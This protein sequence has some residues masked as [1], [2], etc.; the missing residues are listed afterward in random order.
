[1]NGTELSAEEQQELKAMQIVFISIAAMAFLF[2]LGAIVLSQL[3]GPLTPGLKEYHKW[4][5]GGAAIFSLA[6]SLWG[7]QQFARA[8]ETAKTSLNPLSGKLTMYRTSLIIYLA[9]TELPIIFC[10]ILSVLTG[11]FVFQVYAAVLL[12]FM[13]PA[14]PRKEKVLGQLQ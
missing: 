1:M 9:I 8:V 2:L 12:G 7:K 3:R 13:L 14:M 4:L 10:I 11:N 5:L 6:C